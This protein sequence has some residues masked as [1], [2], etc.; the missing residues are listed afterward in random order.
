MKASW[1]RIESPNRERLGVAHQADRR[2][3]RTAAALLTA[4]FALVLTACSHRAEPVAVWSS[5]PHYF[6]Y[7]QKPLVFITSDHH[8]GAVIDRDFDFVKYLDYLATNGMNLTRIYPGGMFE[9][10]DKYLPGNPLGPRPGRQILPWARSS[11][12]GADP[13]LAEPGQPSFK[14]DLDRWNPEYFDRLKAFVEYALRKGIVVEVAF[15]NGMYADCWP[16]MA[17]YHGNNIQ[18]VGAY[19]AG[20][21]GLFTTADERNR[22][23]M[24][25]QKAYV[26]KITVELNAFDNVIYD[27]CDEPSLVGRPDGSITVHPDSLTAPWLLELKD[28][29]LEAETPLPGK[30]ILGQTAQNLSPDFSREPWC[31]W[32]AAEY[33]SPAASAIDSD[34]AANKPIVDVES[35]YFGFG[36]TSPYTATDI[37]LE[38]WWFMLGGGAGFINLNGEYHRGQEAGGKE[39]QSVIVPQKRILMDFMKRLDLAGISRFTGFEGV[40]GDAFASGLAEPGKQYAIYIFHGTNDGKWGAHFVAKSGL[41][42]ETLTLKAVPAGKYVLEWIDP[43]TG[44]VTDRE[45]FPWAGGDLKVTTPLYSIDTALWMHAR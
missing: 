27:L 29:F 23:V 33:V 28:A 2:L 24:K 39:T 36:L 34:Y 37:R 45:E 42:R 38:G 10:P 26:A 13:A 1:N 7:R 44:A 22:G 25:Y 6:Y 11:Q 41:Y 4:T 31:D 15:F 19:E 17:V 9:P 14:F 30:H 5:N 32:V 35:D 18:N 8:Y 3:P 40:P 16:L 21:C 20:E 12:T 43:A